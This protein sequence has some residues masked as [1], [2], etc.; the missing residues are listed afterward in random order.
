MPASRRPRR[1]RRST[2]SMGRSAVRSRRI[3]SGT[4]STRARRAARERSRT[5]IY[6]QNAGDPTKW[7]YVPDLN[8][9]AYTD[10]TWENVS[11][12]VTWQATARNKISGFWDE[13]RICRKCT[14]MTQGITDPR[15]GH[16]RGDRRRLPDPMRV[17]QVTWSS[18]LTNRLLLDAGFGGTVLR[19]G[20]T[21]NGPGIRRGI[22]FASSNSARTA[23]P[24]T[25]IF[26]AWSTDR[27]TGA[28]T[29][30]ARTTGARRPPTSPART[31]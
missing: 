24:P 18:P 9:P 5:S 25:A 20:A 12:R 28:T 31:A 14:G 16:A 2:T 19:M 21:P 29:S 11:G 4:S 30:A 15:A 13:Q 17:T 10:R 23:A 1:S 6:N 26:L 22:S 27:R 8:Q 3:A 7:T